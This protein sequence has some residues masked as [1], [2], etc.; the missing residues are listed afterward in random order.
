MV[1][2]TCNV[3]KRT[4]KKKSHYVFHTITKKNPCVSIKDIITNIINKNNIDNTNV[5]D[6]H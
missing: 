3:C 2:H 1:C 5:I 6:N 4:F